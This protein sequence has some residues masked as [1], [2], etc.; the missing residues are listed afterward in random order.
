ML[1]CIGRPT[2]GHNVR[3]R[4][5]R[6][7]IPA[8]DA[9]VHIFLLAAREKALPEGSCSE[10]GASLAPSREAPSGKYS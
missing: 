10:R 1:D 3:F 8:Q 9:Q 6:P 4:R 7:I 5:S 2:F